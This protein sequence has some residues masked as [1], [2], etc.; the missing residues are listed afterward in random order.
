MIFLLVL[1]MVFF[2]GGMSGV[3]LFTYVTEKRGF[4]PICGQV[5]R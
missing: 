5:Q 4:C 3:L 2:L 1:F